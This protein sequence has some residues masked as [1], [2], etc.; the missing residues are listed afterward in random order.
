[1]L[2]GNINVKTMVG[3]IRF[4][5]VRWLFLQHPTSGEMHVQKKLLRSL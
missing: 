5:T 4:G 1:M 2:M 3:N